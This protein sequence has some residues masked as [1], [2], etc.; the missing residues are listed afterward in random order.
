MSLQPLTWSSSKPSRS[1][2]TKRDMRS[3]LLS[4]SMIR[5]FS[6]WLTQRLKSIS[7]KRNLLFSCHSSRMLR[8]LL[9][10]RLFRS[11]S[12]RKMSLKSQKQPRLRMLW[13]T[14]RSQALMLSKRIASLNLAVSCLSTTLLLELFQ[15]SRE[16][17]LQR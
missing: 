17:I 4:T 13:P 12:R 11:I 6:N 8:K 9:Q 15:I 5:V 14:K 1:S 7:F 10:K 3:I 16:T 2:L